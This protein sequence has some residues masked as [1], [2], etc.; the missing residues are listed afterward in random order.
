MFLQPSRDLRRGKWRGAI[1]IVIYYL[2]G[3]Q[4]PSLHT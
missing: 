2:E 1:R 4:H 3:W